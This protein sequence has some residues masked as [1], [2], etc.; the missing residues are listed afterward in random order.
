MRDLLGDYSVPTNASERESLI[1]LN[2]YVNAG[3]DSYR[4]EDK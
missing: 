4:S 2:T 1:R 3:E